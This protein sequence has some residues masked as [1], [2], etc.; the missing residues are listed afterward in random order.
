MDRDK[1]IRIGP[2]L[3]EIGDLTLDREGLRLLVVSCDGI[4]IN[5]FATLKQKKQ[6]L[7]DD[8]IIP[9]IQT[10]CRGSSPSRLIMPLKIF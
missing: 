10:F 1:S 2:L 9:P 3:W 6:G 7:S 8:E 4:F 5:V